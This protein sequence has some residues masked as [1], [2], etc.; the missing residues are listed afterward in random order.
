MPKK[1]ILDSEKSIIDGPFGVGPVREEQNFNNENPSDG[2]PS[3]WNP[4][5]E[6]PFPGQNPF[7]AP[8]SVELNKKDF[9]DLLVDYGIEDLV[10][11]CELCNP[12]NDQDG[13]GHG[14]GHDHDH[15]PSPSPGQCPGPVFGPD[16]PPG[17][18]YG[19]KKQDP[20]K[21]ET[22]KRD[23]YKHDPRHQAG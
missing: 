5:D 4:N 17:H 15:G 18:K 13:E 1:H 6:R 14:S 9:R 19:F 10:D 11:D 7:G 23:Y 21:P 2:D 22:K 8:N 20:K 16:P 3:D 12:K